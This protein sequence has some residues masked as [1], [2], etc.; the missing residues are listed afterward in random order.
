MFWNRSLQRNEVIKTAS[1]VKC[2]GFDVHIQ[3]SLERQN[4]ETTLRTS[5]SWSSTWIRNRAVNRK[6]WTIRTEPVGSCRVSMMLCSSRNFTCSALDSCLVATCTSRLG[7]WLTAG[8][9]YSVPC[10]VKSWSTSDDT[11]ASNQEVEY[12]WTGD[13]GGAT[14]EVNSGAPCRLQE[15]FLWIAIFVVRCKYDK[16]NQVK[17]PSAVAVWNGFGAAYHEYKGC[18]QWSCMS[19]WDAFRL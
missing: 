2:R 4:I 10:C 14:R 1:D 9:G 8:R 6:C 15:P 3:S 16:C 19:L 5:T 13:W 18:P 7:A 11:L 17:P 12:C